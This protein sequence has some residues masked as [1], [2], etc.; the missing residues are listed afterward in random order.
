MKNSIRFDAGIVFT[1][2]ASLQDSCVIIDENGDIQ[3][4]GLQANA[5][6]G[7]Y[8]RIQAPDMWLAPG[9]I[10]IH[11]HG[12]N[13]I[14]FGMGEHLGE[15]LDAYSTWILK[16]GVTGFLASITAPSHQALCNILETCVP[17]F[18]KGTSGAKALGI[19]LEGPFLNVERKGAFDPSWLRMPSVAEA[20]DYIRIAGKWIR[21]ISIAPELP[22]ALDV[23]REFRKAGIRVALAH[24]DADY[25]T[26]SE[27]LKGDFTHVTHTY[28]AQSGLNHRAPGVVGAVLTSNDIT[29]EL[30]A[31]GKHVKPGAMK[32][33]LRSIGTHRVVLVTDDI[34]AAG[35]PNGEYTSIGQT[36]IV[37]DGKATLTNGTL[38]GSTM[39]LNGGVRNVHQMA[40]VSVQEAIRMATL[41]PAR[42]IN[43]ENQEGIIAAGRKA[44]LALMD[45]D[46]NVHLTM[47]NGKILFNDLK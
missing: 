16:T 20:L 17:I 32:V 18:E 26:A 3:Y 44:D 22:G 28:N 30:I 8:E 38:A 24:S 31:D 13:G 2:T 41:N 35:L 5:P 4:V 42:V 10:D 6:D 21:Q 12:G 36:I 25:D 14:A 39:F 43:M 34:P 33:L 29:G 23:A 1:P 46:F 40:G 11:N 9:L 47:V 19:H 15:D 37:K 27:A 7:G 45:K